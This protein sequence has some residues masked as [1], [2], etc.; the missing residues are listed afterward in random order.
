MA[1]LWLARQTGPAGF[2]KDLVV[3]KILP[4][5]ATDPAFVEMFLNEARYAALLNHPNLVQIFELGED[6]GNY[7]LVLEQVPGHHRPALLR[8]AQE[9]NT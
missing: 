1:E 4:H 2:Q 5:L 7:F 6:T 8:C 3:K 9:D